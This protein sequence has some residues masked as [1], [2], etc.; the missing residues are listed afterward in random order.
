MAEKD[1]AFPFALGTLNRE[2]EEKASECTTVKARLFRPANVSPP[3]DEG[4][5]PFSPSLLL[6]PA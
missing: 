2:S 4:K 5:D 3:P 1:S 6:P